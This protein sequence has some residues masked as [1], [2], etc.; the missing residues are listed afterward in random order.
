MWAKEMLS[1]MC[2]I[3]HQASRIYG[4]EA[5]DAAVRELWNPVFIKLLKSD[6]ERR[7]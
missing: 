5:P 1:G 2:S 3:Y 6:C 7:R 4:K